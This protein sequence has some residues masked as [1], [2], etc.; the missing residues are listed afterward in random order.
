ME[1]LTVREWLAGE[2]LQQYAEIF[3]QNRI[4][5]DV[6]PDL[7]ESDLQGLGI[8]LGDRKRLLKAIRAFAQARANTDESASAPPKQIARA[9]RRQLTVLFCDLVG[10][11]EL[12]T[13]LD[14]EQLRDLMHTY[15]RACSE[16]VERYEGHIAQYLGDGL[17]V[18][19]GWPRAHED[20]AVRAIR[21][22]LEMIA[23]LS[24][25]PATMPIR[26]RVGIHTGLVVVGET[27]DGDASIPKA[28]VG[29]TPNIA[30]RL[31]ALAEPS[32][33]V[34]SGRTHSL[35]GGLFDFIDLGAK[36]LKG[37]AEP[38]RL[39]HVS[40][41]RKVESRFDA[42]RTDS[43]LTPLIGRE[44]EIALLLRRWREA[45]EGE[46][47]V[48]LIGGEPGIGKSRLTRTLREQLGNE[49]YIALRYQCSPY[50]A[51]SALYPVIEQF[52]RAAGFVRD[53][54]ADQKLDK[55]Q[56]VL[57][58]SDVQIA[59]AAPLLA[60]M[61]SLPTDRYPSLSL[62]PQKQKDKT[63]EALAMQVET[64]ALDQT[65]LMIYEDV[66]WIDAT[67]QEAL[68]LLVPR[69]QRLPVML[70]VT[71]RP[72]YSPRW[73]E[74]AHVT[75]LGL[76][77]LGRR[78]GA[79]LVEQ[80]T[81]GK[82]L[83]SDV[84]EQIVTRTDGVPLFVEELTKSVLESK[85]LRDIGDRYALEGA[86]P[87]LAIP[88]TLRDSLIAR[89]DRLAPVREV[90]Q[91]GACIG[92]EFSYELLATVSPLRGPKLDEA[93]EQLTTSGLMF[94]RGAPP[95]ATYTFKHALVQDAAYDSLLKSKRSQ[96]HAQIAQ[97][98][99]TGLT[100]TAQ[101]EPE[102]L[103]HHFTL[104]SLHARA[105]PY[106]IQAG[107]RALARVALPEAVGHLSAALR[108]NELLPTGNE[109][110]RQELDIRLL[111]SAAHLASRGWAAIEVVTTLGPARDLAIRLR[112]DDKLVVIL[113]YIW[114]HQMM[115]CEYARNQE[116][117][118]ELRALAHSRQDSTTAVIAEMAAALSCW[119]TG[120][121]LQAR[122]A[123]ES[124][125]AIYDAEAHGQ[126]AISYV[127][128]PKCLM[129]AWAAEWL[130]ALG[131]P[132][133]AQRAAEE[134]LR[135]ARQ[136]GHPMNLFVS[137][138]VGTVGLTACGE[139]RVAREWLQEAKA[140]AQDLGITFMAE[141][142]VPFWEGCAL[143]A[144]GEHERGHAMLAVG[145]KGWRDTGPLH[146]IPLANMMRAKALTALGQFDEAQ[147]LLDEAVA[148][149]DR[150]GHRS[151]E[152]EMH[153][154]LGELYR[155]RAASDPASAERCFVRALET[156]RMQQA[157]G[158]ELR[159]ASSLARLWQSQHKRREA[160]DLLAAV[161]GWF[162][163][164]FDTKDLKEAK[165][166]LSE[167]S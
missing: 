142:I 154:A 43:G 96:L 124:M 80:L 74:Q 6:L 88:T 36:T 152:P 134:Q 131:Y 159:A 66:H 114:F 95:D 137:L 53:D 63:L 28:A 13:Q 101:V 116:I 27:G 166:L 85:V 24:G 1:S 51:N 136:L 127:H 60:S 14:P 119:F 165:A 22:G 23:A 160:Y 123:A 107:Q 48:V 61:L 155:L 111:L 139:T 94:R 30:A 132:E 64:L 129:V 33:V 84:L 76:S 35:A 11:T 2:G 108:V 58:G 112:E 83:P 79:A 100:K 141:A 4:G 148:I 157:K 19:F 26:A 50:H 38:V 45:K 21:A 104:A 135:L 120:N 7:S 44:E 109:R 15:Q 115:R 52:E 90:A 150:T 97:V 77:R 69:L 133:Q 110:D 29:E 39:L 143:I 158:Y 156:A 40:G 117:V 46:G 113:F 163:E 125:L 42:G 56:A 93:L 16:V 41:P 151:H 144:A 72:E 20:D 146:L 81:G 161:Y 67:S 91:I 9:E 86:L 92:R 98:L 106:W 10:S 87:A 73:S 153:R 130:W 121:P 89:L 118:T 149:I 99:E 167:L 37:V 34:V 25:L 59:E 8:P 68:D 5:L 65:V 71:Y 32:S 78:Q 164:G 147:H 105:V 18:Y 103:A 70:V 47:Q 62:S 17:M 145:A 49:P 140:I 54:T 12:A 102:L 82:S 162:T 128:D 138:S 122:K 126:L 31:Q 3:E 57:A 75:V 55:M